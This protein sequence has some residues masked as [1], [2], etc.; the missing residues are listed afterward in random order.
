MF[1]MERGKQSD[2]NTDERRFGSLFWGFHLDKT[3]TC[4]R[5]TVATRSLGNWRESK[6][7]ESCETFMNSKLLCQWDF[8][9]QPE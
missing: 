2:K 9:T 1:S 4:G 8:V 6:H 5:A 3:H 7:H